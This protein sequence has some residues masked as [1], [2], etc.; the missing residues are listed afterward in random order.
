MRP[1]F[2]E[3]KRAARLFVVPRAG[4]EP[5]RPLGQRIFVPTTA[6]AAYRVI[7]CGLDDAFSMQ[8]AIV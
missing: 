1:A 5:A 6:F 3:E 8:F 7:V 2:L 4:I